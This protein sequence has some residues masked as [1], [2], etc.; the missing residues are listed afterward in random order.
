MSTQLGGL[1]EA[2]VTP[3]APGE[4]K[5]ENE[6]W[7]AILGLCLILPNQN[8]HSKVA[9]DFTSSR[10]LIG[11]YFQ[12]LEAYDGTRPVWFRTEEPVNKQGKVISPERPVL[13][14]LWSL[15]V[16]RDKEQKEIFRSK[17]SKKQ[18]LLCNPEE[19]LMTNRI[20]PPA[21]L[22][23]G[24]LPIGAIVKPGSNNHF[25]LQQWKNLA[26]GLSETV[27]QLGLF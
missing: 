6:D 9:S 21:N 11:G 22:K 8:R 20:S 5:R 1:C 13:L 23:S 19:K 25:V 27:V 17:P 7:G 15:S 4:G 26:L 10:G 16:Q 18:L 2:P 12:G 3:L 24:V 14:Q